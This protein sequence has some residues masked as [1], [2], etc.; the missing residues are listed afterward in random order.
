MSPAARASN[1]IDSFKVLEKRSP[2]VVAQVLDRLPEE[3]RAHYEGTVRTTWIPLEHDARLVTAMVEVLGPAGAREFWR[4]FSTYYIEQPVLKA[5]VEGAKRLFGL[6]MGGIIRMFPRGY[7]HVYRGY[8]E[9]GT[10]EIH[11]EH[12]GTVTLEGVI[13]PVLRCEAYMLV[14]EGSMLGMYDVAGLPDDLEFEVDRAGRRVL[15]H[16]RW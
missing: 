14:T 3:T 11:D 15:G 1:A 13:E 16:F 10:T 7:S 8:W 9:R 5:M 2:G 4:A 6:K 12:S